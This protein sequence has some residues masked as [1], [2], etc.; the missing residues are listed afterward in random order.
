M[1][2]REAVNQTVRS[3][4]SYWEAMI[5]NNYQ[6]PELKQPICT[7]KW[8]EGI[9]AGEYWCPRSRHPRHF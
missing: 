7:I 5:R 6:M 1:I 4:Q 3:K 9:R 8:M 2:S